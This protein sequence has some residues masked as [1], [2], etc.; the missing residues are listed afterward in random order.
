[1]AIKVPIVSDFIDKGIK[2]ATKGFAKLKADV[3]AA[4]GVM[5]KFSAATSGAFGILKANAVAGAAAAGAAIAVFAAKSVMAFQDLALASGKFAD[6]TGLSVEQ[7]SR[8]IEVAGDLGIQTGTIE[9]A[10][11]KLNRAVASGSG[12]FQDIGAEIARTSSGAVDVQ[13]TFLNVVDALNKVKD[14][15]A[16]AKAATELLGKGWTEMSEL[17]AGGSAQLVASLKSVSDAK[18]VDEKEL[19]KAKRFRDSLDDLKGVGED[20]ALSLGEALV[21]ALSDLAEVLVAGVEGLKTI[22]GWLEINESDFTDEIA[23]VNKLKAEQ[24]FLN[25]AWRE[26]YRAQIDAANASQKLTTYMDD[27]ANAVARASAEWD[28]F[29]SSLEFQNEFDQLQKSTSEFAEGWAKAVADGVSNSAEW[30]AA[31]RRRNTHD[32]L[33]RRPDSHQNR[34]RNR[35]NNERD[36]LNEHTPRPVRLIRNGSRNPLRHCRRIWWRT[37]YAGNRSLDRRTIPRPWNRLL[38]LYG[39]G[40]RRS[41]LWP[42]PGSHRRSRPRSSHPARPPQRLRQ[43]RNH[44]QRRR[45]RSHPERPHRSHPSRTR[46]LATQR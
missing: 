45:E 6:S 25:N 17:I 13:R 38:R 1:M 10:F 41:R 23:L 20:L 29:K 32:R 42:D 5:G 24:E 4:N 14:P 16:R 33:S 36:R 39:H 7:A 30:Q 3:A 19:A 43:R 18:V 2:D 37:T 44:S 12:A 28:S 46:K 34:D 21:P 11:N 9:G 27:Q 40:R 15:A 8:F 35:R 26:G 22:H 31:L